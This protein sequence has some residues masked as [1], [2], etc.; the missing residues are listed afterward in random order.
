MV[1]WDGHSW[2]QAGLR[3]Q[4]KAG[5][6]A[7]SPARMPAPPYGKRCLLARVSFT[8]DYG[9]VGIGACGVAANSGPDSAAA[10]RPLR[11]TIERAHIAGTLVAQA[12]SR[13]SARFRR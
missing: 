8:I 10:F 12:D 5:A 4:K 7:G 9:N 2:L 11:H 1:T 3:A 13:S 6:D